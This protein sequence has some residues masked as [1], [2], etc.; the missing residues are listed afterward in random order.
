MNLCQNNI[1]IFTMSLHVLKL[2]VHFQEDGSR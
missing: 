1:L 2:R